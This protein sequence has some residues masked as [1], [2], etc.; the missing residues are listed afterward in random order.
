[1]TV[2][3]KGRC[4]LL[5]IRAKF[6]VVGSVG[7]N[8]DLRADCQVGCFQERCEQ[9]PDAGHE[10][11]DLARKTCRVDP[12]DGIPTYRKLNSDDAPYT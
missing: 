2:Q 3:A 8:N 1:M 5:F 12:V 10:R 4:C 11:Y 6:H 9:Y 7:G